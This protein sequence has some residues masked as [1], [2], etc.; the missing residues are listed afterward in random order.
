MMC[1]L[2]NILYIDTILLKTRKSA[3]TSFLIEIHFSIQIIKFLMKL[4]LL[5]IN[6][7]IPAFWPCRLRDFY[8][9]IFSCTR[10]SICSSHASLPM[11]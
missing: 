6:C 3:G 4:N 11:N 10:F 7:M 8:E 5:S 2:W 1:C 9:I